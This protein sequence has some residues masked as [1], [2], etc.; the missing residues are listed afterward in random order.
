MCLI[1]VLVKTGNNKTELLIW[2]KEFKKFIMFLIISS[3]NLTRMSQLEL[4]IGIHEKIIGPL[5][6]SICFLKDILSTTKICKEK[7]EKTLHSIFLFCFIITKYEH[8]YIIKHKSGIKF[9][10]LSTKLARNDLKNSA[11]YTLFNDMLKDKNGNTI[12]PLSCLEKYD[13]NQYVNIID[14]LDTNEWDE[15]LY[16]NENLKKKLLKDFFTYSNFKNMEN[17]FM[18]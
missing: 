11:I 13:V 12:L 10:N 8:Q 3:S 15:A 2:L 16:K 17:T 6:A 14:L 18:L 1:S 7:I 5:T 9:F 4:Y